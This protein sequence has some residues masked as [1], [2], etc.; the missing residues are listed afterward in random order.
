MVSI[1]DPPDHRSYRE[2]D[3]VAQK[4][5]KLPPAVGA[6][7]RIGE[8]PER[9][10]AAGAHCAKATAPFSTL[11][12]G[13]RAV[14]AVCIIALPFLLHGCGEPHSDAARPLA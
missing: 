10:E 11:P 8:P 2:G 5:G 13:Q 1:L 7:A 12:I 3:E 6:I 14:A 4:A 9:L